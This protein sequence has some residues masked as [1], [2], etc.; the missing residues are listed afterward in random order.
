VLIGRESECARLDELLDRARLGRSGALSIRG[1]AGIGKTALLDY[2]V[3]RAA[4]MTVVRTIGFES[5]AE[6]EFSAL[7]DVCRPLLDHLP[8]IP[9]HQ[10]EALRAALD[11][12]PAV[13]VDR[14]A[15][16][17][18][19]MGLFAAAAEVRPLLV[20]VDDAQW[21]DP[22]SGDALLFAT[23]RLQA[24]RVLVLYAVREGEG[25]LLD[26][27][28]I[29]PVVLAGLTREEATSLVRGQI[30]LS[31]DV[32][33]RLYDA[34]G[35]NPLALIELPGLLSADQLTGASPLEDPLP[36][37]SSVERAYARH[38]EDLPVD[39][40]RAL[41]VAAVSLSDALEP[42]I[43]ALES[44]GLGSD[45]LEPAEDRGLVRLVGGRLE[46]RHPLL[47]SA[48]YHAAKPSERRAAH[49]ALANS[50]V[51]D[52]QTLRAWHL[53]ATAL[54]PDEEIA[55]S[56]E[57]AA[58]RS[59]ERNAHAEAGAA[60]DRAARLTP[61]PARRAMRMARA[62]D[63]AWAAGDP[64]RALG[65][66]DVAE[67]FVDDA[68]ARARLLHL[69]GR[70]ERRVGLHS[71]AR[72]ELLEAEAL[73]RDEDRREAANIMLIAVPVL[74]RSGDVAGAVELGRRL[75]DTADRDGTGLDAHVDVTFG[76]T[77]CQSGRAD[78]ARPSLERA[79]DALLGDGQPA[80]EVGDWRVE[81]RFY[82]WVGLYLAS[83][84]LR[85]LERT[86]EGIEMA[87]RASQVAR[88]KGPTALLSAL[89]L[90]TEWEAWTGRWDLAVAHGEEGLAL[91]RQVGHADQILI[92]LTQLARVDAA[93]G[94][95]ARCRERIDE[96]VAIAREHGIVSTR[97]AAEGVAGG[98]ELG[99]GRFAEAVEVLRRVS[100]EVESSGIH[101]RDNSPHPD[102]VE[103]LVRAGQRD[104]AA[105][106][107][108]R[109]A[110]RARVGTPLW[111]GSLVARGRAMLAEDDG[112][113]E[114]H[115]HEA[116]GLHEQ[117]ED[118][119]QLAR[120]LLTFG[121]R[122]RRSGRRRD[123]RER[124]RAAQELFAELGARP[125]IERAQRELRASGETLRRRD[126]SEAERLTPQELQIALQVA[127]GK[128]N[129]EVGAALFLSHKTVEFHL[130][131]IFRKLDLN[132]R[133]ELI[134]RFA[135]ASEPLTERVSP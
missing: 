42:V 118:R 25:R 57:A 3:G 41:L 89:D 61:D 102:L 84:A 70:I 66:L 129:K 114:A 27:A 24:D 69:R 48:V 92:L 49:R 40:R 16:G 113:A 17:V 33:D 19:T 31:P 123:A 108:D 127:E 62:A 22:S 12:G 63:A 4:D 8:E 47:R 5:E 38:T 81:P 110:E 82:G 56:L 51:E 79:V 115:F 98:L 23:R 133:A 59:R 29:E 93:R 96:A 94:E 128:T 103:A 77:L 11:L 109:Y 44:L 14:F 30:E 37:G 15:I 67:T 58:D 101:D 106:V 135:A 64:V 104:E 126:P 119:F 112:D 53:S 73:V 86:A 85:L 26:M 10:A 97:L 39:S 99:L 60:L 18:A 76:W 121:E 9:G 124:L 75:R 13:T 88:A 72:D 130:S 105:A 132:S 116:L 80:G 107:L 111:G 95:A 21:L 120:T 74:V 43:R 68:A 87:L 65:L 117:V 34:T 55:A 54:G 36:A 32:A 122:L 50:L 1:E 134:R 7:L 83:L 125:W 46:F 90:L 78:E 28:G 52:D 2:A 35:G 131:R 6:L 100:E 20:V 45:A 71:V 91:A